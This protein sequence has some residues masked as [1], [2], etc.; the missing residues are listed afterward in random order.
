MADVSKNNGNW[1]NSTT[2]SAGVP[3]DATNV[4]VKTIVTVDTATA[5][6]HNVTVANGGELDVTGVNGLLEAANLSVNNNGVVNVSG[7]GE[8]LSDGNVSVGLGAVVNVSGN[9]DLEATSLTVSNGASLNASDSA[10]LNVQGVTIAKGGQLNLLDASTL[11]ADAVTVAK[12]A[13][14]F[15][16]GATLDATSIVDKGTIDG[17]GEIDGAV[18]GGGSIVANNGVLIL[19]GDVGTDNAGLSLTI[20]G[21]AT[22]EVNGQL[23]KAGS[24]AAG[25]SKTTVT[26]TNNGVLDLTQE[27]SG[28]SGEV[29][30][31][32]ANVKQFNSTDQIKVGSSS[33]DTHS[34]DTVSYN[35]AAHLLTVTDSHGVVLDQ[36]KLDGNYQ[37]ATLTLTDAGGT[38]VI[39]TNAICFYTGTMIRT[40]DGEVAVETL[41]RGDVVLTS[42][43]ETRKVSW[44]G[45]QTISTMFSDPVRTWPIRIKAGALGANA[46]SRDLVL[47]PDH[48]VL[49]E[50]ALVHAGALVNGTSILREARVPRVFTYYHVEVDDHSLVLAENVPAETFIDNIDRLAF[51]NWDEHLTLFPNGKEMKEMPYPRAKSQRQ[52][53]V[54]IRIALAER[55]Q[56]LGLTAIAVA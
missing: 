47:S 7:N 14:I 27:G 52:V 3:T 5:E 53:P 30:K 4:S 1:A 29:G 56:G 51:D 50:G 35:A 21:G 54:H 9:G 46:P 28:A 44:L 22:L 19:A 26:F 17:N 42:D 49:V 31:F 43:G 25:N 8:L 12:N 11:N 13:E 23:G 24:L 41:K 33:A 55:A 16:N 10:T 39:T 40:P 37:G 6:A 2:W 18:T 38:D 32:Q 36:I 48:A 15:L 20:S 45:R 34:G